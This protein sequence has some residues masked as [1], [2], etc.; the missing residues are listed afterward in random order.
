M[1]APTSTTTRD[2]ITAQ[3]DCMTRILGDITPEAIDD[4]EEELGA[5]LV[6]CKLNHFPQG[7]KYGHLAVILGQARMR[8][9]YADVAYTYTVPIDQGPYDTTI[10]C[11]AGQE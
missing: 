11:T 9:I 8:N 2:A 10:P 7:Q 5:I 6:K 4:L 1:V 3:K